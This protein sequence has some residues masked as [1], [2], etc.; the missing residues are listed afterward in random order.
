MLTCIQ[1]P[2]SLFAWTVVGIHDRK[3]YIGGDSFCQCGELSELYNKRNLQYI[4]NMI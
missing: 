2:T 1:Q 4:L 3:H